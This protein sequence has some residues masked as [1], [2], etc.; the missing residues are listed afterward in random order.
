MLRS[1]RPACKV[2]RKKRYNSYRGGQGTVAPNLPNRQFDAGAPNEKRVPD[3]TESSV[4]E[5]P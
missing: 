1:L 3:K 4:A 5:R 2:R